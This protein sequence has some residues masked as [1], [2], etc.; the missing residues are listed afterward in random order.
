MPWMPP[1]KRASSTCRLTSFPF[2]S[3]VR[4]ASLWQARHSSLLI[5]AP[6]GALLGA[7]TA[8]VDSKNATMQIQPQR[9]KVFLAFAR[10]PQPGRRASRL[11]GLTG[12]SLGDAAGRHLH[13]IS[14]SPIHVPR[15]SEGTHPEV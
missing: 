4:V 3:L 8:S 9:F 11:G 14:K 1:L 6:L 12:T 13:N 7:A 2:S 5:F 15:C 10:Q